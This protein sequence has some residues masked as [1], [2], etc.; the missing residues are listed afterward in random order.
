MLGFWLGLLGFFPPLFSCGPLVRRFRRFWKAPA[1]C[2]PSPSLVDLLDMEEREGLQ[3]GSSGE[4]MG[5][6]WGKPA[7]ITGEEKERDLTS[8]LTKT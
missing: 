5:K 7:R 6:Q 1:G 4:A 8:Y 3:P 2:F